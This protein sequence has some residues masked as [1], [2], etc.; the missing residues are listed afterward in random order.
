MVAN[1]FDASNLQVT[2]R[3]MQVSDTPGTPIQTMG[4]QAAPVEPAVVATAKP[5]T[6]SITPGGMA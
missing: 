1:R 4:I 3:Q 6:P 5:V 2:S